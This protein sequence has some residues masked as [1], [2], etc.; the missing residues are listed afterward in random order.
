MT[1]GMLFAM[2]MGLIPGFS[3]SRK[4]TEFPPWVLHVL[5]FACAE[6]GQGCKG[7]RFGGLPPSNPIN[8]QL[9]TINS[10]FGLPVEGFSQEARRRKVEVLEPLSER[11]KVRKPRRPRGKPE[12]MRGRPEGEKT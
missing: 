6:T 3:A 8:H 5:D 11:M 10:P 4:D 9:A 12:T 1:R 7:S 2:L